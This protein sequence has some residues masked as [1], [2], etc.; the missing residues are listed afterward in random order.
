M[1]AKHRSVWTLHVVHAGFGLAGDA[2]ACVGHSAV[3]QLTAAGFT[4]EDAQQEASDV[5]LEFGLRQC[6]GNSPLPRCAKAGRP[7]VEAKDT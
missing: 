1:V 2:A 7:W 4:E 3:V 6:S 5:E